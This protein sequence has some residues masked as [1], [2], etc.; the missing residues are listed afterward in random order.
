M[1]KH[2]GPSGRP[3]GLAR[4]ILGADKSTAHLAC[5]AGRRRRGIVPGRPAS[6][7]HA[8]PASRAGSAGGRPRNSVTQRRSHCRQE[9]APDDAPA[10][11]PHRPSRRSAELAA[12]AAPWPCLIDISAEPAYECSPT[13]RETHSKVWKEP[14][15]ASAPKIAFLGRQPS[16]RITKSTVDC[17]LNRYELIPRRICEDIIAQAGRVCLWR[18]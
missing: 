5:Q 12:S 4:R 13:F 2:S 7:G 8:R 11:K 3:A 16:E 10:Q 17:L 6:H 9:Y 15:V 1:A 18:Q 14:R